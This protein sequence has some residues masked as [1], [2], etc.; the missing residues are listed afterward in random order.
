MTPGL[1]AEAT[2]EQDQSAAARERRSRRDG[3]GGG[4]VLPADVDDAQR[5]RVERYDW[6]QPHPGGQDSGRDCAE[7]ALVRSA[8]MAQRQ[9]QELEIEQP[10]VIRS[11]AQAG[12]QPSRFRRDGSHMAVDLGARHVW[13]KRAYFAALEVVAEQGGA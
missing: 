3:E 7:R 10:A 12:H 6:D 13:P 9:K 8:A 5:R 2:L 4:L 11:A 1:E